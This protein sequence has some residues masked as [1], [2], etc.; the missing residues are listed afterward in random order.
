MNDL[1]DALELCL[2]EIEKGTDIETVL[3]QYPKYADELRPVLE[4]SVQAIQLATLGPSPEVERRGRAKVLQHAAQMREART[5][6]P[7]RSPRRLWSVPLRRVLVT[8]SVVGVLFISSTQLVQAASTTLPGDN[9]Y[10][11]KRTWE[12]VRVL[13]T[14]NNQAREALEVEHENERLEE[15]NGLFTAGRSAKVDFAGT[16]M[17]QNGDLWEVS[18]IPVLVSAQTELNGQPAVAVGDAVRVRGFTQS[19]GTVTAEHVDLL[20][21]GIPLPN[22]GDDHGPSSEQENQ[23]GEQQN[24]GQ[25]GSGNESEDGVPG[26]QATKAPQVESKNH[27]FSRSGVVDSLNGNTL[28]VNGQS[29]SISGAKIEGTPNVGAKVK[30]EGYFDANGIFVLTKVEFN[31]TGSDGGDSV[32]DNS[33]KDDGKNDNGNNGN[34]ED[35]HENDQKD[36][37]GNSNDVG[38]D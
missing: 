16:V 15:L 33:S 37:N 36:K 18:K 11:V 12:D 9:L 6:S 30:V 19:G 5:Q 14:F 28:I 10:P 38:D 3:S 7:L 34:H 32:K 8:L 26:Q 20:P 29:M 13:F 23:D 22:V 27:E 31:N 2:Q 24:S 35:N 17:S 21:A 1:Y 25:N 4:T